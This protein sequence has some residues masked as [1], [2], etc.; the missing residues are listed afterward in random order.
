MSDTDHPVNADGNKAPHSNPSRSDSESD[1]EP[2]GYAALHWDSEGLPLSNQFDDYYFSKL[3]GLEET[4][5]IYLDHNRLPERF[6]ALEPEQSFVIGETGFGTGLNFLASWILWREQ[7]PTSA[8]LH[9][10]SVEKYPLSH[11]DL[12]RALALWPELG[13]PA[14]QL[15]QAYPQVLHPGFHRLCF[16]QGR[17][18]LTLIIADACDGLSQLQQSLHPAFCYPQRAVDA[19]FLDGFSPAKNPQMWRPELFQKVHQL[20]ANEATV[21]T[22][23][24]ATAVKRG[25]RDNGFDIVTNKGFGKKREMV[26][27]Q[28]STPFV[29]PNA[30]SFDRNS[31][32][33][34]Y[35]VPW[36]VTS[37]AAI[38]DKSV[39]VV[40][41]GIAGCHTALAL[42]KRGWKVTL[43]D[44]Q[45]SLAKEGSGNPQGVLYAKLSHRQETLSDFNLLALQFAQRHYQPYWNHDTNSADSDRESIG[46]QCGV[47]QLAQTDKAAQLQQKLTQA[48]P[49]QALFQQVDTQ[50]ASELSGIDCP[51][52]GVFFRQAGWLNPAHLCRRLCDHPNIQIRLNARVSQLTREK[53]L[54]QLSLSSGETLIS[55]A[56]VLATANQLKQFSHTE[57]VPLKPIRGQVSYLSADSNSQRLKTVI[58]GEGY[59]PPAD[60]GQHCVGATFDP[61]YLELKVRT[62]DHRRNLLT[63]GE[64][65]PSLRGS[66]S[67]DA[68]RGGRAALRCTT[69]DYLPIVGPAPNYDAYLED[70]ALLRKNAR[71]S[72]A[73]AGACW[74]N[75]FLN[76]GHGSRGLAYTP[77]CAEILAAQMNQEPSP[78][79]QTL[80]AALH[81]GRFWIRDL[82]RG[83]R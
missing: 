67:D 74:P 15:S 38:E 25:L 65:L 69:P 48:Y 12:A 46:E 32:N 83:K 71:S 20:S 29:C 37:T 45:S 26:S 60:K 1:S 59:F 40:G 78:V 73:Q 42:A 9:F 17:V 2:G 62:D 61:R 14:Q 58:C 64:Q 5:Y 8:Q 52:G 36:P 27:G 75:L 56:V 22:F 41:G 39:V 63:L 30:D 54:W 34:P 70:Y 80:Q 72:I 19:W 10:I 53:G 6:S 79:G 16:D 33:S 4:Q 23:A 43:L 11:D 31:F 44:Q 13:E 49:Q 82:T 35:P 28:L 21:A 47:L 3:N 7:A 18:Q 77:I 55:P 66:L 50:T 51:T 76:V 81:P 57:Q 24:A 68:I